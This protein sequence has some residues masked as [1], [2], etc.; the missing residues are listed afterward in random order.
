MDAGIKQLSGRLGI[1]EE[2]ISDMSQRVFKRD[3]SLDA[4]TKVDD[5]TRVMDLQENTSLDNADEMVALKEELHLL[6]EAIEVLRPDLNQRELFV[7]DN[8]LLSDEPLTLQ[9]IGNRYGITREAARQ[10]ESRLLKKIKE[11]M[12]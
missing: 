4:P 10:M 12:I 5:S 6:G 9:E 3:V 1:P 7:L 2:E 11:K 8:R